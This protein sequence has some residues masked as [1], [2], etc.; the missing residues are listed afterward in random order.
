MLLSRT[1][2]GFSLS[3]KVPVLLELALEV[4]LEDIVYRSTVYT[5]TWYDAHAHIYE[6]F[7]NTRSRKEMEK[8][9]LRMRVR[10]PSTL[11][12]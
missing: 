5:W 12:G 7:L 10:M 3:R 6:I 8:S 1:S 9:K 4:P 11:A 2:T